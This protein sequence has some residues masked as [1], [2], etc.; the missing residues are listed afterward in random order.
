MW[1]TIPYLYRA[2]AQTQPQISSWFGSQVLI[3]QAYI[4]FLIQSQKWISTVP[5]TLSPS[6]FSSTIESDWE[7]QKQCV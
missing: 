7:A 2:K 3:D 1:L 5:S 4:L 6:T